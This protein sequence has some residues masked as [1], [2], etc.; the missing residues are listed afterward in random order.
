MAVV[1]ESSRLRS[2]GLEPSYDWSPIAYDDSVERDP[3]T[4]VAVTEEQELY[5]DPWSE[6]LATMSAEELFDWFGPTDP[7]LHNPRA[8]DLDEEHGPAY[9][10]SRLD[11]CQA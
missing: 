11:L 9:D 7:A 6:L 5:G 3:L 1:V 4:G 8:V 2:D 10:G